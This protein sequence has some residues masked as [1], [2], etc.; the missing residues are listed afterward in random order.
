[1]AYY[2]LVDAQTV[3]GEMGNTGTVILDCR[4]DLANPQAGEAAYRAGHIPGSLFANLNQHLSAP[5]TAESGRHPLPDEEFFAQMLG[6]WGIDNHTQVIA[7]D[8]VGGGFAARLWWMCRW[9][10]L[11]TVAVLNGGI[12]AWIAAGYPVDTS[13]P[14]PTHRTFTPQEKRREWVDTNTIATAVEDQSLL[15]IDARTPERFQGR[16]EPIDPVAGHIPGAINIP[17]TGNLDANGRFLDSG[18]LKSRFEAVL[19]D[20][21]AEEVIHYCGSGVSACHNLL[22]MEV[23]GL[24]GTRLYPGSWSEW[25]RDSQRP[26][27]PTR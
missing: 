26:I 19:R 8:D 16:E 25:I 6:S 4:F 21:L 9:L 11:E 12:Q 24:P 22:A 27:A 15:L 23:A 7:Y 1:M 20:R 17:F 10:G 5:V 18:V 13:I 14:S 2:T 3:I